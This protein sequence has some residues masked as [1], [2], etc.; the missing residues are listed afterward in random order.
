MDNIFTH[1]HIYTE[2]SPYNII[3]IALNLTRTKHRHMLPRSMKVLQCPR[4]FIISKIIIIQLKII[5]SVLTDV[6]RK[7][8]TIGHWQDD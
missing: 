7:T 1:A 3:I 4:H 6:A 8:N 5:I 2:M